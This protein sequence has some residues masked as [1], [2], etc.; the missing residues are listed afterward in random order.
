LFKCSGL[1]D[2]D[3]LGDEIVMN[4]DKDTIKAKFLFQ[5]DNYEET[6]RIFS[7]RQD[8]VPANF[9]FFRTGIIFDPV[10]G[11][12]ETVFMKTSKA[13]LDYDAL[14]ENSTNYWSFD[15]LL[16]KKDF[17]ETEYYV[18]PYL[19]IE[20]PEMPEEFWDALGR[21]KQEFNL[22]YLDYP[23]KIR[24]DKIKVVKN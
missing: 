3:E 9:G 8:K 18:F 6:T 16:Y 17:E 22:N 4:F 12:H 19:I 13:Q 15:S 10:D 14:L 24:K 21:E 11:N 20:H 7:L 5:L 1:L 2:P 23:I